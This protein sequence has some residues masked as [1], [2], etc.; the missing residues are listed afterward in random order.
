MRSGWIA[1][2]A[3]NPE[4][5]I[6]KLIQKLFSGRLP[7]LPFHMSDKSVSNVTITGRCSLCGI[8]GTKLSE[9]FF[10]NVR[11][12]YTERCQIEYNIC[13]GT[14]TQVSRSEWC[15]HKNT[16]IFYKEDKEKLLSNLPISKKRK[17]FTIDVGFSNVGDGDSSQFR[18]GKSQEKSP[19]GLIHQ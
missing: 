9:I 10:G 17:L 14:L 12:E 13:H 16:G 3:R 5:Q 6:Q 15:H 2:H 18:V 11:I 8:R 19:A 1:I 7:C 4:K